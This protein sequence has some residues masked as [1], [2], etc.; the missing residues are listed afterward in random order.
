[1][2]KRSTLRAQSTI[3]LLVLAGILVLVNLL[4]VKAFGRLDLTRDRIFSLSAASVDLMRGLDDRLVVKAYFTRNLPGRFAALE[5]HVRD[6]LEEYR[7]H[8]GGRMEISFID[9]ADDADEEE[10]ARNLGIQKMPNPDIVKDQ[11]T[12]KEG[13]R[14]LAFTY[15][16]RT[17]TIPAVESPVGLEYAITTT[18]K[19][20]AG[21][22]ADVAF[23]VGHGE[24]EMDPPENP[25]RPLLPEE[26]KAQG[27]YRNVRN[28]L[29]IYNYRQLD[30]KGGEQ[31]IPP[32][33]DALVVVGSRAPA[34][35]DKEL[36]RL[37]QFLLGGGSLA[38]FVNG[39]DV[40]VKPA[41]LPMLPPVYL[42]EVNDA[43]LRG[44][45]EHHGVALG[46]DLVFDSQA[47]EFVAKCPPLPL[48][49]PRPY[50]PWPLVRAFDQESPVTFRL[51]TL[52]MPY[53]SPVRVTKAAAGSGDKDAREIAFSSG[54]SW[55]VPG[56]DA[57]V[58]PCGIAESRNLDSGI[59]LA[60]HISGKFDSF[61]A[62]KEPPV[63]EPLPAGG[64]A[65][66]PGVAGFLERSARPGRLLVVGT[67]ALPMDESLMYLARLD[68]R[69]AGNN[70]TF[71]QNAL[72]WLT[73]EDDLI[74]VRMKNI[75]D[76][77]LS[78]GTETSRAVAKWGNIIGVPALFV[79][80]G[81][82][83]WRLR[84]A[85]RKRKSAAPG[86]QAPGGGVA[87]EAGGDR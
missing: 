54:S 57:V 41:D 37:D 46:R 60:A 64:E 33:I 12:I 20:L 70:F 68:R 23:L 38:F 34:F 85:R 16:H 36:Y 28:N 14:G 67:S 35:T 72:D 30:L 84:S 71:V 63:A 32:E 40:D 76:P 39:V 7:Q 87:A 13:Y 50:P 27:A 78:M 52:T 65:P 51:G 17:E 81:L 6:V 62:G 22:K 29:E 31:P 19:K 56:D 1:M 80:F 9:P 59:P 77:P 11:A 10:V 69:Q 15:G 4:S 73:N 48:P 42:T 18:V 5:R 55:I 82:V 75:D 83:R 21:L 66:G 58:E 3:F 49:L 45:L 74:A 2:G 47:A 8:S 53:G 25:E 61:F 43:N 79:L 86:P 26:R 44:F 24:P